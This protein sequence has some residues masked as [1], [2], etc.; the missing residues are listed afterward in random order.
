[1]RLVR[2]VGRRIHRIVIS[3]VVPIKRAT[4]KVSGELADGV[5]APMVKKKFHART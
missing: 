1:V 2:F 3:D 5:T 4:V